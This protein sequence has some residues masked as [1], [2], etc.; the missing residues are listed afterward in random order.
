MGAEVLIMLVGSLVGSFA[1]NFQVEGTDYWAWEERHRKPL[2][3]SIL[4]AWL[5]QL[6]F[7][8]LSVLQCH[9]CLNHHWRYLEMC[10]RAICM[11]CVPFFFPHPCMVD[12]WQPHWLPAALCSWVILPPK[13]D[14]LWKGFLEWSHLAFWR[15]PSCFPGPLEGDLLE[16][17]VWQ[18]PCQNS[19]M[20]LPWL[21]LL[22]FCYWFWFCFMLLVCIIPILIG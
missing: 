1:T 17:P 11:S 14:L 16:A 15:R 7:W 2:L 13:H 3:F 22:W 10:R 8:G 6:P 9:V 4:T 18:H 20:G 12:L 21:L 19:R 5:Q